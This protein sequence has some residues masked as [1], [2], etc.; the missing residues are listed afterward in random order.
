M[1]RGAVRQFVEQEQA[2]RRAGDLFLAGP[3]VPH[4][5]TV[6]KPPVEYIVAYF[7]PGL[8]LGSGGGGN[9]SQILHRFTARQKIDG[10]LIR[11][12]AA[13]Q[14]RIDAG[15]EQMLAEFTSTT[16]GRDVRLYTLLLDML[17][18]LLR[19]ERR[20][21]AN[22]LEEAAAPAIA[23]QVVEAALQFLRKNFART[24]Y[25]RDVAKAAGV[26]QSGLEAMFKDAMGM[27]WVKYLQGYR[28]ERAIVL[29]LEGRQ[30]VTEV[31]YSVGFE[32]LSHFN[33]TFRSFTGRSPSQ[34]L[35][36]E[37]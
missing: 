14:K 33:T 35:R 24:V 11:P 37:Q 10:R 23:W 31:A 27:P 21:G 26:S 17:V 8:L 15:L 19:W 12:P 32:S 16:F 36:R 29:L 3:W 4:W 34:Y 30:N 2:V 13:L 25:S 20:A 9:A 6:V 28:V 7:Q 1:R 22:V 5:A 18:D